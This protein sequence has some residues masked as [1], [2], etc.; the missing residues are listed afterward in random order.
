MSRSSWKGHLVNKFL[1]HPS[2][3]KILIWC[4]NSVVP[5]SLIEKYIFIHDGKSFHKKYITREKV[6]FKFGE[7]VPTRRHSKNSKN[8]KTKKR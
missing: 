8:N 6:G 7:L 5:S 4:R 3:K 2:K 1:F